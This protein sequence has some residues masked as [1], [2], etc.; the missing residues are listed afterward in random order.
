MTRLD[1]VARAVR[2]G[3]QQ[4]TN[5]NP[6]HDSILDPLSLHPRFLWV[7]GD[8]AAR[9][10]SA[11]GINGIRRGGHD[12]GFIGAKGRSS[13]NARIPDGTVLLQ[14]AVRR[15]RKTQRRVKGAR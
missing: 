13:S 2:S 15:K 3:D 12:S 5:G 9:L 14:H 4:F 10:H 7:F 1:D 6:H 11:R 8:R